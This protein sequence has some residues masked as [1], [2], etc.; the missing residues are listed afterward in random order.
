MRYTTQLS[1]NQP[2]D[3]VTLIVND[4]FNK[5]GFK[6]VN[7]KNEMVWK[8]GSGILTAPQYIKIVYQNGTVFL[9]AWLRFAILPGVFVGE[10]GLDGFVGV[11]PKQALK[12][13]IDALMALLAQNGAAYA[14]QPAIN[15]Q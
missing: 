8:K 3:F 14:Q 5:E 4:F 1:I 6:Y 2:E 15:Q 7:Y 9:D 12:S 13:K 10:M 11:I